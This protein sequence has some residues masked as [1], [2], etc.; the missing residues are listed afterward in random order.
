M[1][2]ELKTNKTEKIVNTIE[3]YKN[4]A[5][6]LK[7]YGFRWKCGEAPDEFI[8]PSFPTMIHFGYDGTSAKRISYQEIRN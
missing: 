4:L 5:I 1:P 7:Q 3:E 2:L 6:K 8:P